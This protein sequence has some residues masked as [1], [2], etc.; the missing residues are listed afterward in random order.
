MCRML[1]MSF[2]ISDSGKFYFHFRLIKFWPTDQAIF[3]L[4]DSRHLESRRRHVMRSL[5]VEV[6][7]RCD[8]I[9]TGGQQS[10]PQPSS[11]PTI[12]SSA[13]APSSSIVPS[14]RKEKPLGSFVSLSHQ[15]HA[16]L[17]RSSFIKSQL[18]YHAF[19]FALLQICRLC[20]FPRCNLSEGRYPNKPWQSRC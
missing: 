1:E 11:T 19:D 5:V 10:A 6:Q 7:V 12:Q 9:I 14:S 2:K 8:M 20:S 18:T 16:F 17:L 15:P 13:T 3:R 4:D